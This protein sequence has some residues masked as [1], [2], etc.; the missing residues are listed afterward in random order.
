MKGIAHRIIQTCDRCGQLYNW[1]PGPGWC[2]YCDLTHAQRTKSLSD[3]SGPA[4]PCPVECCP[5]IHA[6]T[7]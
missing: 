7:S 3:G 2:P 6:V 1:A 5:Q 4:E